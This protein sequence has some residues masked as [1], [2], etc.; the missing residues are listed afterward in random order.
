ML[1]PRPFLAASR[2][3]LAR[4][5]ASTATGPPSSTPP[6]RPPPPLDP[7]S[8]LA[9][10]PTA[11]LLRG[12]AVLSACRVPG[13]ASHAGGLLSAALAFPPARWALRH[14]FFAQ[15]CAGETDDEVDATAARLRE[16]GIGRLDGG[17]GG[18][19]GE[20]GVA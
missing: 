5:L 8:A 4:A 3:L 19:G 1:A 17:G 7:R 10:V 6:P 16:A 20:G 13:L 18:G 2:H 9:R 15:F 12:W 11:D 14:T